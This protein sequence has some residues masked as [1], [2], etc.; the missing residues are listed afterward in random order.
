MDGWV[1]G[2]LVS[3][4]AGWMG[5]WMDGWMDGLSEV[6][7]APPSYYLRLSHERACQLQHVT[8]QMP[9]SGEGVGVRV[10]KRAPNQR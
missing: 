8:V 6:T 7:R 4:L 5:G 1:D 9:G 2:W 3:W 10:L